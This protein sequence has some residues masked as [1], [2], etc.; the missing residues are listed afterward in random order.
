[1]LSPFDDEGVVRG[2]E[3]EVRQQKGSDRGGN[4]GGE[5]AHHGDRN[6]RE[7]IQQQHAA[8][9]QVTPQRDETP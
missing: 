1:M 3:E 5:P 2:D 6:D 8:Q 9:G 7:Q 4:P